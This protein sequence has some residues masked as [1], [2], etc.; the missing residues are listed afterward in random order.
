MIVFCE[1]CGSQNSLPDDPGLCREKA[2]FTCQTCGYGNAWALHEK[3][4][5]ARFFS[6]VKHCP[7]LIGAFLFH[8]TKGL[9]LAQM[10]GLLSRRELDALGRG[11]TQ[12]HAA[13]MAACPDISTTTVQ[14]RDK[15]FRVVDLGRE[16]YAVIVSVLPDLDPDI[17]RLVNPLRH[18]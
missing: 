9:V 17:V 12:S 16:L 4:P 14:I 7:D 18:A 1:D 6:A 13:A 5:A 3:H 15:Y 11:L 8:S 2:V 10:P